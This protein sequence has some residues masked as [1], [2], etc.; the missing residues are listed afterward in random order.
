MWPFSKKEGE[1]KAGEETGADERYGAARIE[2]AQL[3]WKQ[4]TRFLE[5]RRPEKAI[6]S[7]EEAYAIEPT[8]LEGRLNL[9]AA[10]YLA[11]RPDEALPHLKYVLAHRAAQHHRVAQPGG[12]LRCAGAHR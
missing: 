12:D 4:G 5:R 1:E 6:E 3:L 9:G 10:L 7:F 8:R 11:K 2:R